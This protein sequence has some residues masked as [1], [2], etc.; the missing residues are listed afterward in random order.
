MNH[1][2]LT[3]AWSSL[4]QRQVWFVYSSEREMLGIDWNKSIT[5]QHRIKEGEIVQVMWYDTITIRLLSLL[6]K[7]IKCREDQSEVSNFCYNKSKTF[8]GVRILLQWF[9]KVSC[10]PIQYAWIHTHS[11]MCTL[12][13]VSGC[14]TASL[15]AISQFFAFHEP[16][17]N[18]EMHAGCLLDR[19]GSVERKQN[20][21]GHP[22]VHQQT[23]TTPTGD[24]LDS[25][26]QTIS[27]LLLN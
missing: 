24:T 19:L 16:H 4:A 2:E 20:S 9:R 3:L 6:Q 15:L 11:D 25:P 8:T 7:T 17:K 14:C 21:E 10:I 13:Q 26:T 27:V 1:S 12:L 22:A 18:M 23:D 5:K